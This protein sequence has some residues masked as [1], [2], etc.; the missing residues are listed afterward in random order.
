MFINKFPDDD[1]PAKKSK[2]SLDFSSTQTKPT[3]ASPLK[4]TGDSMEIDHLVPEPVI[5]SARPA[6]PV[7]S[8]QVRAKSPSLAVVQQALNG[9]DLRKR[10][11]DHLFGDIDDI[12]SDE[13]PEFTNYHLGWLR[14]FL[15]Y[16]LY[17]IGSFH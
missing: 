11:S 12:G 4:L 7:T 5:P 1:R 9:S 10:K 6:I 3:P 8:T 13:E 2:K 17:R 14:S 16:I 15:Y